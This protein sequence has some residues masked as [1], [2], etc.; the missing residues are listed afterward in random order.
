MKKK[1][2]VSS[3]TA[4]KAASRY[5]KKAALRYQVMWDGVC[6]RIENWVRLNK[7][8]GWTHPSLCC[9]FGLQKLEE[10]MEMLQCIAMYPQQSLTTCSA[11]LIYA[12]TGNS[13]RSAYC[14]L[15]MTKRV[16]MFTLFSSHWFVLCCF[17]KNW[18]Q[19]LLS[20]S[21]TI[22]TL[23]TDLRSICFSLSLKKVR[24]CLSFGCQ[25]V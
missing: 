11:G 8:A 18:T 14:L 6:S 19:V 9:F 13:M 3:L 17:K 1:G 5:A 4:K 25:T 21:V 15:Q 7:K 20:L 2:W 16:Y 24:C 12:K 10:I 23:R 22:P